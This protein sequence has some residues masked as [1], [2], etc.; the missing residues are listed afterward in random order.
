VGLDDGALPRS[1]HR[2]G[3]DLIA[4]H[5]RAGDPDPRIEDRQ[6]LL[7]AILSAGEHLVVTYTGHDART[8]ELRQPAVPI[9][10]L[11]DV[12]G[13]TLTI[14]GA[15]G[16]VVQAR[17][18]TSH[19]LQPHSPR[20]FH[21][22]VDGEDEVP[23]AFDRR[24]LAAA[25]TSLGARIPAP[26]FLPADHPLPMP[27]EDE[28]DPH[29]IELADLIRFLEHPVR[30]LLQRRVGILLGEDDR[31]LEDRD[32]TEIGHLE[33]WKLGQD[34][35]DRS[36]A[37]AAPTRWRELTLACGTVPVGG[38][39]EVA[40]DGIEE[41]VDKLCDCVSGIPGDRA[42]LPI[43]VLVPMPGVAGEEL[44]SRRIVG[45]VDLI[46]STV[47]H[48]SVSTLKA[49]HRIAT[50]T[51][52]LA[53]TATQPARRPSARLIGRDGRVKAG[54]R[55]HT[56]KPLADTRPEHDERDG[57]AIAAQHLGELVAL[58]LRGQAEP[59]PLLPEVSRAY[60]DCR[61]KGKGH[62]EA[63]RSVLSVWEGNDK[64]PGEQ[65]DAYVVQAFASGCDLAD[66]AER[67]TFADDAMQVWQPIIAAEVGT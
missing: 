18:V 20:Y 17:L 26:D 64:H 47:A 19:P 35:L 40:L 58:Y 29:L 31:R 36:L 3:F 59:V 67:T 65:Q 34:L 63:I 51:R 50:W 15:S 10:E 44:P 55:D 49:K 48:V 45:S 12:L 27:G 37:G 52:L 42:P 60:A 32:P 21:D 22:A 4:A 28:L 62:A 13:E 11:L 33:R 16:E 24:Q 9:S 54:Y 46:G 56:L 30:H 61:L 6:L 41:L 43:D 53:A 8:N 25:V 14:D 57:A 23:R 7:D 1:S 2:H 66:L 38:I 5:P 39:G